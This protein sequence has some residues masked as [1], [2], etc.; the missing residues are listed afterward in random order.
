MSNHTIRR[1]GIIGLGAIGKRV[2]HALQTQHLPDAVYAAIDHAPHAEGYVLEKQLSLFTE[3]QHLIDWQ[4]DLVIECAGHGAV[5]HSV[6]AF[7]QAGIDVVIASI[8]ALADT[9]LAHDLEQA[10]Q[11]GGARLILVSGAIGG[12]DAM[13]S[14]RAAGLDEVLYV[15][16]KPPQAWAGTPAEEQFDLAQI[17]VPTTIFRGTAAQA[18]SR[19]PKNANV[20]AAVALSGVGFDQTQV[21]LVADPTVDKNVHEV[22]ARGAFGELSIRLANNPLPDNVKTSWLAALSIEEAV[23]KQLLTLVF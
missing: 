3:V 5:V 19:F 10:A 6:P 1:V 16:R 7:L 9:A 2:L 18:S 11:R 13:R 8:G 21:E 14:A 23:S 15:G 20:T 17:T 4:P 12:L 22:N